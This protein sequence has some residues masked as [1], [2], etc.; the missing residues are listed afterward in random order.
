VTDAQLIE[1]LRA[2]D[3]TAFTAVVTCYHAMFSRI[4]R[5]WVG[6]AAEEVVQQTWL[7]MLESLDRFEQRSSLRTWLYGIVVNTARSHARA[8]RRLEPLDD[9]TDDRFQSEGLWAG[10]WAEEPAPFAAVARAELRQ[11]L[12]AAIAELPP[13]QQQVVL[14]CD[15]EGLSGDEACNILGIASTHQRVLLHRART[16]LRGILS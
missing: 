2:G 7:V 16:K 3:E 15:V 8:I 1:A 4:A 13:A 11:R 10:H 5:V 12:E 14:L 6:D 9:E